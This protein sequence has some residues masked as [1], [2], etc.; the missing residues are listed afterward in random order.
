MTASLPFDKF[1][2][3]DTGCRSR[4]HPGYWR[5]Q[6]LPLV[7]NS[8]YE[9]DITTQQSD[10]GRIPPSPEGGSYT[11]LAPPKSVKLGARPGLR[12]AQKRVAVILLVRPC[13]D[14]R[15]G[16]PSPRKPE[17]RQVHWPGLPR[18][19]SE[20]SYPSAE[21]P[22]LVIAARPAPGLTISATFPGPPASLQIL[23]PRPTGPEIHAAS[24][25]V[26]NTSP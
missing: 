18:D 5:E 11:P 23:R 17:P 8:R 2:S 26:S 3:P 16:C 12:V 9:R 15:Q 20:I 7:T 21:S 1:A 10:H 4:N 14:Q 6:P 24:R 13:P 22:L 19:K 25:R